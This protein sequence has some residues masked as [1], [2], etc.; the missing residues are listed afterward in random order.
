MKCICMATAT[1]CNYVGAEMRAS[2]KFIL[3]RLQP[4]SVV[5]CAIISHPAVFNVL[6]NSCQAI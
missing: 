5:T 2:G 4:N 6:Y 3:A 1:T